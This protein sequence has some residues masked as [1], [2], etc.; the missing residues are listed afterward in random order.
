MYY[1]NSTYY[2]N[3][4]ILIMDGLKE[5]T[6]WPPEKGYLIW[7]KHPKYKETFVGEVERDI[8][9]GKGV[10]V[11]LDVG[12]D[13]MDEQ[14]QD[15]DIDIKFRGRAGLFLLLQKYKWGYANEDMIK[16]I[17]K[18]RS[19]A[20]K[21]LITSKLFSEQDADLLLDKTV[22]PMRS[23]TDVYNSLISRTLHQFLPPEEKI[24]TNPKITAQNLITV[25][26]DE[27]I[28]GTKIIEWVRKNVAFDKDFKGDS[29]FVNL[30]GMINTGY[31]YF[32]WHGKRVTD[33]ITP[34]LVPNLKIFNWQYNIP[35][36][37]RTLKHTLLQNIYQ[38]NLDVD[39]SELREAENILSQ[40]YIIVLQPEPK[41]L[42]WCLKRLLQC[43]IVD[44]KLS[45]SIR[46]IK[47]LIN[48]WRADKYFKFNRIYSVL[49]MI[50]IYPKYGS[51]YAK[52]VLSQ[53]TYWYSLY[54]HIG[55][56]QNSPTY[57]VKVNDLIYYTNGNLD[58]K[59]YYHSSV[60]HSNKSISNTIFDPLLTKFRKAPEILHLGDENEDV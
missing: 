9:E 58:L 59:F 8:F 5:S 49:P 2:Y 33:R 43:C 39:M 44:T 10:I 6:T 46:K 3:R 27:D 16:M 56:T 47:V 29:P 36:D 20:D 57:C 22:K 37:Y 40:E 18:S 19:K 15:E 11:K 21:D 23:V 32:S 24:I 38:K 25:Q 53:I 14:L 34:H 7:M 26:E 12:D 54:K 60:M 1:N 51:K 4:P 42:A 45:E 48:T 30:R 35:I 31:V 17:Y 13:Y 50:S 41:F 55:W 52:R 28:E